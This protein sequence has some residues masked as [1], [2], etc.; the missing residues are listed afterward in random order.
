VPTSARP[1]FGP[2]CRHAQVPFPKRQ[3]HERPRLRH[4]GSNPSASQSF[5]RSQLLYTMTTQM[6]TIARVSVES[7]PS[8]TTTNAVRNSSKTAQI[9]DE[10]NAPNQKV[11][12]QHIKDRD[13][14]RSHPRP[15]RD[16]L[17][18]IALLLLSIP[19]KNCNPNGDQHTQNNNSIRAHYPPFRAILSI[20]S[21]KE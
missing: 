9:I 5:S 16:T 1:A 3:S 6:P 4:Y 13:E 11:G 19:T 14:N 21:G 7:V 20:P 17:T 12:E 2:D 15:R 18:P 8:R 10:R